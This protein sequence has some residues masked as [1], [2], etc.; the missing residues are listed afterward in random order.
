MPRKKKL[1]ECIRRHGAGYRAVVT[2][3]TG[4][5][6]RSLTMPTVEE[7]VEWR[8]NFR[9]AEAQPATLPPLTLAVGLELIKDELAETAAREA[10]T[11][12]YVNHSRPLFAGLGG[13]SALVHRLTA[14]D[15]RRYIDLRLAAG[16]NASTVV[17]K[18]LFVLRRLMKLA[19]AK[20]YVLPADPF[21]G[22]RLP[23]FRVGRFDCMTKERV[24][25]CV[26]AMR[27]SAKG[28]AAWHADL[29]ELLFATGIRRAELSRLRVRDIEFDNARISVD[30]KTGHRYQTFGASLEPVLRRLVAKAQRN[31]HLVASFRVV[32]KAF[33]RW[34]KKLGEPR[35]M[36]HVLRHSYATFMA[37]RVEPL[38]LMGLMGHTTLAQTSRY[39][40]ARGDA[41]RGALDALQLGPQPPPP[42]P[43]PP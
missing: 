5:R 35:F 21:A 11:A 36:P 26:A 14:V 8:D 43:S 9:A 27:A 25:E 37:N 17:G 19:R 6:Q 30:G 31:G 12:F 13:D 4:E 3:A 15:L 28:K 22:L 10:T 16:V 32:E 39:Y 18:E 41:L 20:G 29:A 33:E 1:P 2:D 24:A 23:K 34:Q 38:E 40:H 7:A 42:T